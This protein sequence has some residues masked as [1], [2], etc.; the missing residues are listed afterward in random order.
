MFAIFSNT[1]W[2]WLQEGREGRW[3]PELIGP[4]DIPLDI[5]GTLNSLLGSGLITDAS[6]ANFREIIRTEVAAPPGSANLSTAQR[7]D[8]KQP[9]GT[10]RVCMCGG[11][12]RFWF[13]HWQKAWGNVPVLQSIN[14]I[15]RWL[16]PTQAIRHRM[17]RMFGAACMTNCKLWKWWLE[18]VVGKGSGCALPRA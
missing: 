3:T 17:V 14:C 2:Y 12:G 18:R 6:V 1:V 9:H 15:L 4:G 11:R 10:N 7:L 8:N 16:Y 13:I 5:P